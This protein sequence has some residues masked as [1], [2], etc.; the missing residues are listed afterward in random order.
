MKLSGAPARWRWA[1]GLATL[2]LPSLWGQTDAAE[3]RLSAVNTSSNVFSPYMRFL[4]PDLPVDR[5]LILKTKVPLRPTG[6]VRPDSNGTLTVVPNT[7]PAAFINQSTLFMPLANSAPYPGQFKLSFANLQFENPPG[8]YSGH[9]ILTNR[10]TVK[11]QSPWENR[12]SLPLSDEINLPNPVTLYVNK[13]E[14]R[15]AYIEYSGGGS[16]QVG[17]ARPKRERM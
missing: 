11:A 2:S 17:K 8:G 10:Q 15:Y 14:I 13:P 7:T 16:L 4:R 3:A 5:R 6:I 9:L 1:L 12:L